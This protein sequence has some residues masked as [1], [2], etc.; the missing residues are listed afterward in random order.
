M[1]FDIRVPIGLLFVITGVLLTGEG[2]WS[3][4]SQAPGSSG[5]QVNVACGVV[6][7]VFG[8]IALLVARLRNRPKT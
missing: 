7:I 1:P 3:G 4:V 8:S 2:F 5:L 6:M